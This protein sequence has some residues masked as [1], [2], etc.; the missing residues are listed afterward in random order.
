MKCEDIR[1]TS[2]LTDTGHYELVM[3]FG[4]RNA[5]ATFQRA[6]KS[7][8]KENGIKN[9]GNYFDDIVVHSETFDEHLQHP[10]AL[11]KALVAANIKLK[12]RKCPSARSTIDYLR[13][14]IS[15]GIV[16]PKRENIKAILDFLKLKN[17]RQPAIPGNYECAQK[18]HSTFQLCQPSI[19]EP[20]PKEQE[21][22]MVV[23][24]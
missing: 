18:I 21:L 12:F 20:P 1:K 10:E 22:G 13:H 17:V 6:I 3:P 24:V 7:V 19:I 15:C 4:L 16:S 5:P 2:F 8:V 9:V 23:G 14:T 11:S